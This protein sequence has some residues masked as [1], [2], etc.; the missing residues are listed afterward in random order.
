MDNGTYRGKVVQWALG[1]TGTGKEQVAVT[2][3]LPEPDERIT[4][5]GYFTEKTEERTF[6]TLRM[7]GWRGDDISDL[8]EIQDAECQAVVENEEYEGKVRAKVKWL[9]ALDGPVLQNQM[10]PSASKSFAARMRARVKA[11]DVSDGKP[12]ANGK[13]VTKA[14][15]KVG[16]LPPEPP[17]ISDSDDD[18][19]PPF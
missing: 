10:D 12:K 11:F 19:L 6:R 2:L 13:P 17:P 1:T 5:F 18:S 15:P 9:N 3:Y 14:T 16:V 8:S 7:L 4:W